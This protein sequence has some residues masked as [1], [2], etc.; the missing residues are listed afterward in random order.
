M[1]GAGPRLG[2]AL[3]RAGEDYLEAI[4]RLAG[5]DSPGRERSVRSVDVAD[6]LGVSKASVNKALF[7]LKEAGMVEQSRYGRVMLTPRGREYA[8]HVW[9]AHRALRLFLEQDLGVEPETADA[10]A[11]LVEHALSADTM[12]RLIGYLERRGIMVPE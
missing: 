8:A 7:S 1:S 2:H 4:Y 6:R 5:A 9:R 12:G 10:E 3:S 11:C